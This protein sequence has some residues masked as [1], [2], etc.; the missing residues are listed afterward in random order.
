MVRRVVALGRQQQHTLPRARRLQD[1]LQAR[2]EHLLAQVHEHAALAARRAHRASPRRR[3]QPV[4]PPRRRV[5]RHAPRDISS[6][7]VEQGAEVDLAQRP[8][9]LAPLA[10]LGRRCRRRRAARARGLDRRRVQ[11][12]R[13]GLIDDLVRP[14]LPDE[15]QARVGRVLARAAQPRC[16]P[17]RAAARVRHVVVV[18]HPRHAEARPALLHRRLPHQQLGVDRRDGLRQPRPPHVAHVHSHRLRVLSHRAARRV[19]ALHREQVA[20]AA[21]LA[22]GS[23]E[24]VE[25][26]PSPP[27]PEARPSAQLLAARERLVDVHREVRLEPPSSVHMQ[28]EPRAAQHRRARAHLVHR[29]EHVLH[30]PQHP[31]SLQQ[32]ARLRDERR[33]RRLAL[34]PR[35]EGLARRRR[36]SQERPA[37]PLRAQP[38]SLIP[39][40]ALR[41]VL[42][43]EPRAELRLR[44][45]VDPVRD[46]ARPPHPFV[47]AARAAEAA[48]H[49]GRPLGQSGQ[50]P[51]VVRVPRHDLS[52]SKCLARELVLP[53]HTGSVASVRMHGSQQR[54]VPPQPSPRPCVSLASAQLGPP[55][56]A[57][58]DV[59]QES[60]V[61]RERHLR[62]RYRAD[63][64]RIERAHARARLG[65]ARVGDGLVCVGHGGDGDGDGARGY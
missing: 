52:R 45:Q 35:R 2:V 37:E 10:P 14:R 7:R 18:R 21:W 28:P 38:H 8:V 16:H 41:E 3:H 25:P 4:E 11:V 32:P 61:R 13:R 5:V 55:L 9:A 49:R 29:A 27:A 50:H 30:P 39:R 1:L 43:A 36:R 31:A 51:H 56:S 42:L 54:E 34:P 19:A 59:L 6:A 62:P 65:R 12:R 15:L 64:H 46:R 40:V 47:G 23:S 26:Q 63:P 24:R 53:R 60:S 57:T 20:P 48:Q 22:H 44:G 58:E 33:L 17:P